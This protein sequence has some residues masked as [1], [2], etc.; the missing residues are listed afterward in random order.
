MGGLALLL[1]IGTVVQADA[2]RKLQKEATTGQAQIAKAQTF[3]NVD[4]AVIQ[5]TAK[6]AA[7]NNDPALRDLLARNGVIFHVASPTQ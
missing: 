6:S 7:D 2:N 5:L 3:A 4:N 1:A